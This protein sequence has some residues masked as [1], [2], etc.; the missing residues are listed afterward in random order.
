MWPCRGLGRLCLGVPCVLRA[1]IPPA[2][3]FSTAFGLSAQLAPGP[4]LHE[5]P[6]SGLS[7]VNVKDT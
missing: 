2:L 1:P 3:A 5:R 4:G 6:G 7:G